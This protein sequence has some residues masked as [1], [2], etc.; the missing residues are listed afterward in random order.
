M[1]KYTS[2]MVL[3]SMKNFIR[4]VCLFTLFIFT[5]ANL[6]MA[7]ERP[8]LGNIQTSSK[9]LTQ[10]EFGYKKACQNYVPYEVAVRNNN[11]VP[12]V[13]TA[14]TRVEFISADGTVTPSD[15]RRQIYRKSKRFDHS[16]HIIGALPWSVPSNVRLARNMM[17]EKP[18]PIRFEPGKVYNFRVFAPVSV[19]NPVA[20][21]ITNLTFDRKTS[22]DI[23]IPL[24]NVEEL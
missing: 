13:V 9:K 12:V 4:L 17:I 24:E 21:N 14:N 22:C 23:K 15:S 10:E 6:A 11:P 18:L 8:V 5:S 2:G 1:L 20:V 7:A 16:K 19:T 3:Y